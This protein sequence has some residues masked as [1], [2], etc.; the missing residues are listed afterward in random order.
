MFWQQNYTK[1][2]FT[3]FD[4]SPSISATFSDLPCLHT[5]LSLFHQQTHPTQNV[6]L[7]GPVQAIPTNC[8]LTLLLPLYPPS[9][10][11]WNHLAE[12]SSVE[13]DL[14][15]TSEKTSLVKLRPFL[16]IFEPYLHFDVKVFSLYLP[17][18]WEMV[19]HRTIL[20]ASCL[21]DIWLRVERNGR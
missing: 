9:C 14:S 17:L 13:R 19:N 15:F 18:W 3:H 5:M 16:P 10:G 20:S 12:D 11:I 4:T 7:T 6:I 21:P 8:Q 2:F 1:K